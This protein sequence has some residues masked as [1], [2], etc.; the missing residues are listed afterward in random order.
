[1]KKYKPYFIIF[2]VLIALCY[3][4]YFGIIKCQHNFWTDWIGGIV[5]IGCYQ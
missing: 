1:M 5:G 3:Y 2:L 4:F